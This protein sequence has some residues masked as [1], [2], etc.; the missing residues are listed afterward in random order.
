MTRVRWRPRCAVCLAGHRRHSLLGLMADLLGYFA[1]EVGFLL[2]SRRLET[3]PILDLVCDAS[4]LLVH[5]FHSRFEGFRGLAKGSLSPG[6]FL[7]GSTIKSK[8]KVICTRTF[9]RGTQEK[10][11]HLHQLANLAKDSARH[12]VHVVPLLQH[13]AARNS[14]WA[15]S[16]YAVHLPFGGTRPQAPHM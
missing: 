4:T 15:S 2:R 14:V 7:A 1:G 13:I 10:R 3:T 9:G 11:P 6:G 5:C 8:D 12:D 16:M